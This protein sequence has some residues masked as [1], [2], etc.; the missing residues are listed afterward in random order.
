MTDELA[1]RRAPDTEVVR[2]AMQL[3]GQIPTTWV[4]Q[5]DLSHLEDRGL[6]LLVAAGLVEHRFSLR[7][8]SP[9]DKQAVAARV[10]FTGEGGLIKG[11][12]PALA[13]AWA[14]W[15][16]AWDAGR[17]V[18]VEPADERDEWRL[19]EH[20]E[21]AAAEAASGD[22]RYLRN[23]LRTP[24][25]PGIKPLPA[26]FTFEEDGIRYT[27]IPG[28]VR[29]IV[30]GTGVAERV[31]VV[32]TASEPLS[33]RVENLSELTGPLRGIQRA[34]EAGCERLAAVRTNATAKKS[35]RPKTKEPRARVVRDREWQGKPQT[36]WRNICCRFKYAEGTGTRIE[37]YSV[38]GTRCRACYHPP[39]KE[40]GGATAMMTYL[41]FAA[42]AHN[43]EP[44]EVT[45]DDFLTGSRST[46]PE[47]A[48]RAR[49]R[50]LNDALVRLNLPPNAFSLIEGETLSVR[51]A[52]SIRIDAHD[53][54]PVNESRLSRDDMASMGI[55]PEET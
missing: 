19:T 8:R 7:L 46:Q 47:R 17:G 11:F 2:A 18:Y 44:Q 39:G 49:I 53:R 6:E 13:E 3:L 36:S 4:E 34:I 51:F 25:C 15:E 30:E 10:R 40:R 28:L 1:G 42:K 20:G 45:L 52:C 12:E 48:A 50:R 22:V 26:L 55:Y 31:Q 38:K 35:G 33:V 5:P 24:G 54:P 43:C 23:F 14:L 27:F 21:Q 29:P 37:F 16:A 9:G 41:L 32:N